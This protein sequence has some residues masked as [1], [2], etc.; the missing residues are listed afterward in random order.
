MISH[1][2]QLFI[3]HI[4]STLKLLTSNKCNYSIGICS[5]AIVFTVSCTMISILSTTPILYLRLAEQE[6]GQMDMVISALEESG[7]NLLNYTQVSSITHTATPRWTF[8]VEYFNCQPFEGDEWIYYGNTSNIHEIC[9]LS[10]CFDKYCEGPQASNNLYLIDSKQELNIGLGEGWELEALKENE[11]YIPNSMKSELNVKEGDEIYVKVPTIQLQYIIQP[12]IETNDT[13]I[14]DYIFLKTKIASFYSDDYGKFAG[15]LVGIL[16]YKHFITLLQNSLPQHLI[17]FK[18]YFNDIDLYTA[19]RT[20]VVNVP[21]PRSDMYMETNYDVMQA[22]VT[23]YLSQVLYDLGFHE[24]SS[25]TPV[26]SSLSSYRYANVILGMIVQIAIIVLLSLSAILVHS[27]LTIN[28][29]SQAHTLRIQRTIGI[30]RF[31]VGIQILMNSIAYSIPAV[32]FGAILSTVI[33]VV[34]S[35]ITNV[36]FGIPITF[37]PS[38]L[39][40]ILAILLSFAVPIISSSYPIIQTLKRGITTRPTLAVEVKIERKHTSYY[41]TAAI[42]V[43]IFS[44]IFGVCSYVLLPWSLLSLRLGLMYAIFGGFVL[45]LLLGCVLLALNFESIL[46]RF[47]LYL[48]FFWDRA[49]VGISVKN[50]IAHKK[51]NQVTSLLFAL[52]LAF[53]LFFYS[54]YTTNTGTIEQTIKKLYGC[55]MMVSSSYT[56]ATSN[57]YYLNNLARDAAN[58]DGVAGVGYNFYSL[59]RYA[60]QR[61]VLA[62]TG[63]YI[64]YKETFEPIL[65]NAFEVLFE[66]YL[67]MASR[68][69]VKSIGDMDKQAVGKLLYCSDGLYQSI[70]GPTIADIVNLRDGYSLLVARQL[71]SELKRISLLNVIALLDSSPRYIL[72]SSPLITTQDILVSL[73]EY[74][75]FT[76]GRISSVDQIRI[77]DI[78]IRLK[79]PSLSS[80]HSIRDQLERNGIKFEIVEEEIDM[81]STIENIFTFYFVFVTGVALAT[82]FF[83]ILSSMHANVQ[84]QISEIAILRAIGSPRLLLIRAYLEESFVVVL[85]SSL[86]G[87]IVGSIVGFTMTIQM[88]LFTETPITYTFPTAIVVTVFICSVLFAILSTFIPLFSVLRKQPMELLRQSA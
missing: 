29:D 25:T 79:D 54:A 52:S 20:V 12:Y 39:G 40:C 64:Q 61:L 38:I 17:D 78:F 84:E 16:E 80:A 85:S 63:Q 24:L 1:L 6:T 59:D 3:F 88:T 45:C 23:E 55:D 87:M 48:M 83:S 22:K 49:G 13:S 81:L 46:E 21:T 2:L 72:S 68:S 28:I 82:S 58:L 75:R 62:T 47:C 41:S 36:T 14:P 50:L 53:I 66:N 65:P 19:A 73:P 8:D 9:Y 34:A 32:V 18:N 4:N 5:I 70:I 26:L 7:G 51:R 33:F 76:H 11:I 35:L 57:N 31:N 43:G 71:N 27:L 67:S 60:S 42:L 30:R 44:T 56:R 86:L 77:S 10:E 74:I 69:H 15:D 37:L